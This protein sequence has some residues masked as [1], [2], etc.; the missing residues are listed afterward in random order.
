M[1]KFITRFVG[2]VVYHGAAALVFVALG[3]IVKDQIDHYSDK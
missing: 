2:A 1:T 3:I